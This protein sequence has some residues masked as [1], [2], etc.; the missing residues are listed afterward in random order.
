MRLGT[1]IYGLLLGK[2]YRLLTPLRTYIRCDTVRAR[3]VRSTT[4]LLFP[5]QTF[6]ENHNYNHKT[7]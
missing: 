7:K 1:R 2:E 5:K 4:E 6:L 3:Y